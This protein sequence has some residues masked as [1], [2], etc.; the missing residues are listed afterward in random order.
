ME[1]IYANNKVKQQCTSL[2]VA[3]K[4]F[5]G[6]KGLAINLLSRVNTIVAADIIKDII[7]APQHHFH[8][9]QGKME[10]LFAIDVKTRRDKW[11]IILCPLDDN[12]EVYDPCHIDQIAS[13]V[14]IVKIMEV[15]AHY[16]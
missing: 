5:G 11:R 4:L 3:T 8:K 15:S 9:L 12:E 6:N 7:V 2:K 13:T 10:G 1:I 16:E 14:K